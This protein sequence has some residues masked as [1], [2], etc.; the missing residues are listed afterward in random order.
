[1]GATPSVNTCLVSTCYGPDAPLGDNRRAGLLCPEPAK[2]REP[3]A[4]G[5]CDV[6][7]WGH[8]LVLS[9]LKFWGLRTCPIPPSLDFHQ[10]N[11]QRHLISHGPES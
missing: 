5:L 4:V 1:M 10:G 9:S 11:F 2:P 8:R 6:C 3:A 7:Y